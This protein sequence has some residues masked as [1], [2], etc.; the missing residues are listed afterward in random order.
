M[1]IVGY[2]PSETQAI[3]MRNYKNLII[4]TETDGNLIK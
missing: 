2:P 1:S 4:T 3:V